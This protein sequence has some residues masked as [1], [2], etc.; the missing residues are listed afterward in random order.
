M[1]KGLPELLLL[2]KIIIK[3]YNINQKTPPGVIIYNI[4]NNLQYFL[5]VKSIINLQLE[6][7]FFF[8]R[9]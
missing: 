1:H 7:Y 4:Y 3:C 8:V 5:S 6:S 9:S 2:K